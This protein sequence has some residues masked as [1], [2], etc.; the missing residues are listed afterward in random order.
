MWAV[1]QFPVLWEH[2]TTLEGIRYRIHQAEPI[3]L[4]GN[5]VFI[6]DIQLTSPADKYRIGLENIQH[7]VIVGDL[8]QTPLTFFGFGKTLEQRIENAL[9]SFLPS[10]F[11][12]NVYFISAYNHDPML[13]AF[14]T[15]QS[16][17]FRP[18]VIA[19]ASPTTNIDLPVPGPPAMIPHVPV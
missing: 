14:G 19:S 15:V 7:V 6:S 13:R 9:K 11:E 8:F 18:N 17:N 5:A 1:T 12:G 3:T 4:T 16:P 2:K 10:H